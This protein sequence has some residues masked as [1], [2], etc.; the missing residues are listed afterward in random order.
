LVE[1]LAAATSKARKLGAA[2]H[3]E[4][5]PV[6]NMGVFSIVTDPTGATFALWEARS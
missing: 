6:Q 5:I 2:I 1:D 3:Q 4:N